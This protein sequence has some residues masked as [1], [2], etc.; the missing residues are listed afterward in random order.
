MQQFNL[1]IDCT[2]QCIMIVYRVTW[3]LEKPRR[4]EFP[5][6]WRRGVRS[7]EIRMPAAAIILIASTWNEYRRASS[8]WSCLRD[9]PLALVKDNYSLELAAC[10]DKG[11]GYETER[12]V[13]VRLIYLTR[14]DRVIGAPTRVKTLLL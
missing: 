13:L 5:P 3:N 4:T 7:C 10:I 6:F 1:S 12:K 11:Y 14:G 2:S 8:A 9:T